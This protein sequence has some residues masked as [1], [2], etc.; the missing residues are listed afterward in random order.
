MDSSE[1]DSPERVS[2]LSTPG[3]DLQDHRVVQASLSPIDAIRPTLGDER[4]GQKVSI[5]HSRPEP[6]TIVEPNNRLEPIS[7]D[8]EHA[9]TDDEGDEGKA[10]LSSPVAPNSAAISGSAPH[11]GISKRMR[12]R[13]SNVGRSR[14]SSPSTS[15]SS[16]PPNSVDA[17]AEPRLRERAG[18][19]G[20]KAPSELGVAISRTISGGT[21]GRRPTFSSARPGVE[22]LRQD[23]DRPEEDVCFPRLDEPTKTFSIDFEEMEEFVVESK[24]GN[25]PIGGDRRKHS[26]SCSSTAPSPKNASGEAAAGTPVKLPSSG[27][28]SAVNEMLKVPTL[29]EKVE[30]RFKSAPDADP[31]RYSFFSSELEKTVHAPELGDLL[32]EGESFRD[33]FELPQETG[34]WWLDVM[35]PTED[36][37]E[38]FQKAFGVHR[39]TAEDIERQEIR[40]KV[41]LFQ[42]YY[43]VCFRSFFQ[44]DKKSPDY[45]EPVNIYM[46]VF[47]EGILTFSYS[48][49]PHASEVRKRIGK[50]RNYINLTADWICYALMYA[51]VFLRLL[52]E[53][54]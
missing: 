29:E 19:F 35:N 11:R 8:F 43:F 30:R 6:I 5:T 26:F 9:V 21:H 10:M 27:S 1:K 16:S 31:V 20:S 2:R 33:L 52:K 42:K 51:L 36:E 12:E 49:N 37:L 53:P 7:K 46:V 48:K 39:L 41:E 15:R 17:F 45:L 23:S 50:L 24:R 28:E 32:A 18:T 40:E 54:R 3:P 38:M 4:P 25:P 13:L 44:M 34:A 14:E 22:E 47:R